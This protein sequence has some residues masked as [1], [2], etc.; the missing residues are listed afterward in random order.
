[1][2]FTKVYA[3]GG[4]EV[5]MECEEYQTS[6]HVEKNGKIIVSEEQYKLIKE[7]LA[8]NLTVHTVM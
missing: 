3:F 4:M 8:K 5:I 7:S 6:L 1:M 2:L